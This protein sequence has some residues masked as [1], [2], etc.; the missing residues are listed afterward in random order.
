[1]CLGMMWLYDHRKFAIS[2]AYWPPMACWYLC[3][4]PGTRH[5]VGR[6]T[7]YPGKVR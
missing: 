6:V 5:Q 4:V 2:H 7:W 1:M 3:L